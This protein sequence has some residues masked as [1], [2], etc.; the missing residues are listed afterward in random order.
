MKVLIAI[1]DSKES[2]NVIEQIG[3][4]PWRAETEFKVLTVV[5]SIDAHNWTDW[6][7]GV[8]EEFLAGL[9]AK[10]ADLVTRYSSRIKA[11]MDG[12]NFL[13]EKVRTGHV[14]DEI[15]QE[16]NEWN[17][18]LLVIG[19]H[20]S[21]GVKDVVLGNNAKYL[22]NHAPCSVQIIKI[23]PFRAPARTEQRT[24]SHNDLSQISNCV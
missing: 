9:Q 16:I 1:N 21:H 24:A 13:E 15:M 14:C 5:G 7:L 8:N 4:R 22:L 17:A 11:L 18:D 12:G 2:R 19:A 10:A 6:G 3:T 20:E 23:K